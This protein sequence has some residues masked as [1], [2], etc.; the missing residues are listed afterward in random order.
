M[1]WFGI[2]Y[3]WPRA[4]SRQINLSFQYPTL[5]RERGKDGITAKVGKWALGTGWR[6][7]LIIMFVLLC[8]SLC[9]WSQRGQLHGCHHPG[10]LSY[11][12]I[13]ARKYH[14]VGWLMC[15]SLS[16]ILVCSLLGSGCVLNF[17]KSL[18]QPHVTFRDWPW[19]TS[20]ERGIWTLCCHMIVGMV[21]IY[22][23]H[24]G[25]RGEGPHRRNGSG[26]CCNCFSNPQ[27]SLSTAAWE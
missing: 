12:L 27:F 5:K 25:W 26:S 8:I 21:S 17:T 22:Q 24:S 15:I 10:P 4:M 11:F 6:V 13:S 16:N 9:P 2:F 14:L 1:Q 7:Y 3:L 18:L 20:Q 19:P 23:S